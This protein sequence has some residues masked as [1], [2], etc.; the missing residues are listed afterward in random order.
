MELSIG[1]KI[2]TLRQQKELTQDELATH[3]GI[4][5]QSVSKWERGVSHT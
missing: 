1:K 5:F 2:K 3:L 4:S